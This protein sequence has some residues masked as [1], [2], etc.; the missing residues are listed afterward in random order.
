ME[1]VKTGLPI[2]FGAQEDHAGAKLI[3]WTSGL[4]AVIAGNLMYDRLGDWIH[5]IEELEAE[6]EAE[7]EQ[8]EQSIEEH[9]QDI[10]QQL[11]RKVGKN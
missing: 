11:E 9:I 10:N 7:I 2:L 6:L 4:T 3:A 1:I 8:E 5:R